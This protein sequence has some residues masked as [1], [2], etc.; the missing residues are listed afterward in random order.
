MQ[1][2]LDI[3]YNLLENPC[4]STQEGRTCLH[5]TA[6]NNQPEELYDLLVKVGANPD[7]NDIHGRKPAYYINRPD[8]LDIEGPLGNN[9]NPMAR[10]TSY[11]NNSSSTNGTGG[12]RSFSRGAAA[13]NRFGRRISPISPKSGNDLF[14][15]C[16][17]VTCSR[18]GQDYS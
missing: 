2:Q 3:L 5:Y 6:A 11:N 9:T 1:P 4:S 16:N 18:S 12:G 14:L 13:G 7:V 8:E 15:P 10:G 17:D